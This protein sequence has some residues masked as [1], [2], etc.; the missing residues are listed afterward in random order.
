MLHQAL[1]IDAIYFVQHHATIL[2]C[3]AVMDTVLIKAM[4]VT[5]NH[6][7][8]IL[9]MMKAIALVSCDS[10]LSIVLFLNEAL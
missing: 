8:A 9:T 6:M 5:I 7:T 2:R 4:P 3:N 1:I 10:A